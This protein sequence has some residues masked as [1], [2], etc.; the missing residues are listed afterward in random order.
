M[1]IQGD[2]V[3]NR[4]KGF[5][6][7]I[8]D[9]VVLDSHEPYFSHPA[10]L[11]ETGNY[12]KRFANINS[13]IVQVIIN[14][15]YCL[16][17][18][19]HAHRALET[20][21]DV[22]QYLKNARAEERPLLGQAYTYLAAGYQSLSY[23]DEAIEL[24]NRAVQIFP[25][26]S[27]ALL[28]RQNLI[29]AGA[30]RK[31]IMRYAISP[32]G[33]RHLHT[34]YYTPLKKTY[35]KREVM[36]RFEIV[37]FQKKPNTSDLNSG[38]FTAWLSLL[39]SIKKD[40]TAPGTHNYER[41]ARETYSNRLEEC[42]TSKHKTGSGYNRRVTRP[43]A[44]CESWDRRCIF[45]RI[46]SY[47]K[48]TY[49]YRATL[50]HLNPIMHAGSFVQHAILLRL[51]MGRI[52]NLSPNSWNSGTGPLFTGVFLLTPNGRNPKIY[53]PLIY[54]V[55]TRILTNLFTT[56]RGSNGSQFYY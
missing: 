35:I 16:T 31:G 25:E 55:P 36:M 7:S 51:Y 44:P 11:S 52:K 33:Q 50:L 54:F 13:N 47:L 26:N 28:F 24:Y 38:I 23:F 19:G 9:P 22:I 39:E 42:E 43:G 46:K 37:S 34:W 48:R 18:S 49:R 56:N 21:I 29:N 10:D 27:T 41:L 14:Y 2:G 1:S 17:V 15:S 45:F 30:A 32:D 20:L 6:T 12:F 8:L 5:G 4:R 53:K 40:P 3:S